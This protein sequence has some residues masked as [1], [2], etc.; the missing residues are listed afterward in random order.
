MAGRRKAEHTVT[1]TAEA[2]E[3][4][5]DAIEE[6]PTRYRARALADI[7]FEGPNETFAMIRK[8]RRFSTDS[9]P[10]DPERMELL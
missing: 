10:F 9:I 7:T 1:E 3:A 2:A 4:T 5:A 6:A 8:G